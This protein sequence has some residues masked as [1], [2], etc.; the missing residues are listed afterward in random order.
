MKDI[1]SLPHIRGTQENAPVAIAPTVST[2]LLP[3]KSHHTPPPILQAARALNV[4][5]H[6]FRDGLLVGDL[7]DDLE[8]TLHSDDDADML[9]HSQARILD[10]LFKRI[11]A[12]EVHST[13]WKNEPILRSD[14]LEM[15]LKTQRHCRTTLETL[16]RVRSRRMRDDNE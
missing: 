7:V 8:A 2:S 3:S 6:P 10:T 13:T 5:A 15:A 12:H 4:C 11:A 14:K 16:S 1:P 9:L